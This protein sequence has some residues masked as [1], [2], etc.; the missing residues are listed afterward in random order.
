M[1][2][3]TEVLAPGTS[4]R[5]LAGAFILTKQTE[6]KS[7]RTIEFYADNLRRFLWYAETEGWPREIELISVWHIRTFLGYLT[8]EKNRWGLTG[9]CSETSQSR[10]SY[11]TVTHYY[12]AL[13]AFYSW[14]VREGFL[15][16]NIMKKNRIIRSLF[17]SSVRCSMRSDFSLI[18]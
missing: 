16:E 3:S 11:T 1:I 7:P 6:A 15:A 8:A 14:I 18:Q 9:N 13:K 17:L 2:L 12:N 5:S 4:L 10:A